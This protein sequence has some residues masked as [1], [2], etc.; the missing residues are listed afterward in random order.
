MVDGNPCIQSWADDNGNIATCAVSRSHVLSNYFERSPRVVDIHNQSRQHEL[1]TEEAWLTQDCWFRLAT[2][3][4][5]VCVTVGWK[6]VNF[7]SP[8]PTPTQP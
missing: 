7:T 6:L 8:L 4:A 3:L 1:A 5:G 2:T